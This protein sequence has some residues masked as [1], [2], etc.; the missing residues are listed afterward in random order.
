MKV[1]DKTPFLS[2]KGEISLF[3]RVKGTLRYGF[4]WYPELKAQQ[5]VI[6]RLEKHLEKH[7]ILIRN[8]T[9]GNTGVVVPMVLVGPTGVYVL[10]VTHLRGVYRAKG[11]SWGPV[12]DNRFQPARINLLSHVA[13]LA[14]A[15]QVFLQKQG[16]EGLGIVE[17]VLLAADPGMHIESIRP[18][19]RI[20]MSDALERFA[21]SVSQANPVISP[22]TIRD[23]V[24]HILNPRPPKPA[25]PAE[26]PLPEPTTFEIPTLETSIVQPREEETPAWNPAELDFAFQDE[27]PQSEAESFTPSPFTD[28]VISE[29]DSLESHQPHR[30][31][32]KFFGMSGKQFALLAVMVVVEIIVL[33]VFIWLFFLN[34]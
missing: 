17:P 21:I 23:L 13:R 11:D 1:I 34:F 20:V 32:R 19:A 16:Y 33:A 27:E 31:T 15:V 7:Y 30:T 4:N 29:L 22:E 10:Y 5:A 25:Q 3:D 8:H 12:G 9:L 2:D 14:R 26:T 24:D 28:K 6:S 18:I